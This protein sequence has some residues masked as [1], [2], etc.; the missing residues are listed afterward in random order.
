VCELLKAMNEQFSNF[1]HSLY[2][3]AANFKIFQMHK[4]LTHHRQPGV[5]W[6]DDDKMFHSFSHSLSEPKMLNVY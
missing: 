5:G 4:T 1:S 6:V 3:H 2:A